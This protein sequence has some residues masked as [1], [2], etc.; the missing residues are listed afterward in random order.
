MGAAR[1]ASQQFLCGLAHI[2]AH[3]IVHR[4]IKPSNILMSGPPHES[5]P[6]GSIKI[7]DFG[8][9]QRTAEFAPSSVGT[10]MFLAPEL[11]LASQVPSQLATKVDIW[12]AGLTMYYIVTKQLPFNAQTLDQLFMK[13]AQSEPPPANLHLVA[14]GPWF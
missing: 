14:C 9:A 6:A 1:N 13:I 2:H 3:E 4:D 8:S 5:M 7:S 10:A 12:A 11:A